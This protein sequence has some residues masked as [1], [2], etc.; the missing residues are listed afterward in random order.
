MKRV[1]DQLGFEGGAIEA[2]RV[3]D[4]PGN[5]RFY[6]VRSESALAD[7]VDPGD[8]AMLYGEAAFATEADLRVAFLNAARNMRWSHVRRC[9]GWCGYVIL[10]TAERVREALERLRGE[11]AFPKWHCQEASVAL[12]LALK[13]RGYQAIVLEG[14]FQL[15]RPLGLEASEPNE[16][17]DEA[18]HWWVDVDGL[19][20]DITADQFA[21]YVTDQLPGVY[22]LPAGAAGKYA[23]HGPAETAEYETDDLVQAVLSEL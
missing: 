18:A 19:W 20:V 3:D 2:V 11:E 7:F 13:R 5:P 4:V 6:L 16:V 14:S 15:D 12:A 10:D 23:P 22:L 8:E 1:L 17:V 9:T 21:E